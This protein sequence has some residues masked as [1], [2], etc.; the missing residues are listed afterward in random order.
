MTTD[1]PYLVD[2]S[3]GNHLAP[4]GGKAK[5]SAENQW[6]EYT[7]EFFS[8]FLA[9]AIEHLKPNSAI[10]QWHAYKR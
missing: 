6:D 10:Y 8:G 4:A 3:G 2:Y 7:V 5:K 9:P 1:P